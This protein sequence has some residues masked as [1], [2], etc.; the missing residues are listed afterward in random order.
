MSDSKTKKINEPEDRAEQFRKKMAHKL[1]LDTDFFK[2]RTQ[3]SKPAEK[4][5]TRQIEEL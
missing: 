1:N 4:I 5:T 2:K 3:K